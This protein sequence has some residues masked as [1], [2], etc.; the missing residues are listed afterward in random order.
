MVSTLN[1]HPE[2]WGSIP[3]VSLNFFLVFL[4]FLLILRKKYSF[5]NQKVQNSTQKLFVQFH[6]FKLFLYAYITY[7]EKKGV[8]SSGTFIADN[9]YV[10]NSVI[11]VEN[12]LLEDK[13]FKKYN[14]T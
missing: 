12:V 6:Y 5:I 14:T 11:T 1:S 13:K 3:P 10:L 7:N 8:K 9:H 4:F 2:N